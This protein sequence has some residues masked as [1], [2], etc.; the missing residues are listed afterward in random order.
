MIYF[1]NEHEVNINYKNGRKKVQR[2]VW[3][4]N[5]HLLNKRANRQLEM[6]SCHCAS[7]LDAP[8]PIETWY[9]CFLMLFEH[10]KQH[11]DNVK[12]CCWFDVLFKCDFGMQVLRQ[13]VWQPSNVSLASCFQAEQ[14]WFC[15]PEISFLRCGKY[16][17]PTNFPWKGLY[18]WLTLVKSTACA[19]RW[20]QMKSYK[21]F[22]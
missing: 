13:A 18:Y 9:I 16:G 21:S 2:T 11:N 12:I 8:V 15:M 10:K 1:D 20:S 6:S 17:W 3:R 14:S 7:L 19:A 5:P 22:T 4:N